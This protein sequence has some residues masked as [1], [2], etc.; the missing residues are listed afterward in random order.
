M[1]ATPW[2]QRFE[3]LEIAHRP[4][5]T[6]DVSTG[7][8]FPGVESPPLGGSIPVLTLLRREALTASIE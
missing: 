4:L 6:I 8:G 5:L 7:N 1:A 3:R 2:V